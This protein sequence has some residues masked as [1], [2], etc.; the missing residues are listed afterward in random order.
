MSSIGVRLIARVQAR[1]AG[2][3]SKQIGDLNNLKRPECETD[4]Q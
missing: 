4:R 2:G 1:E 3:L